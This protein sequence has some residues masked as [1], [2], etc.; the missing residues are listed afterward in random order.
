MVKFKLKVLILIFFIDTFIIVITLSVDKGAQTHTAVMTH[1]P[2]P[3][4]SSSLTCHRYE[5][6]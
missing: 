3:Q 2:P 4:V 1:Q 6:R 5:V